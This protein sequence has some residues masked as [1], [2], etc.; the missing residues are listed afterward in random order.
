[1][2]SCRSISQEFN[3]KEE[4]LIVFKSYIGITSG[5]MDKKVAQ[6]LNNVFAT[7]IHQS[8]QN[9]D[10][11]VYNDFDVAFA[12]GIVFKLL[13]GQKIEFL[14]YFC[15]QYS[16]ANDKQKYALDL[17]KYTVYQLDKSDP[18]FYL[19]TLLKNKNIPNQQL[20]AGI[21]LSK[22][23]TF[24]HLCELGSFF[25]PFQTYFPNVFWQ[26]YEKINMKDV[27]PDI[28]LYFYQPSPSFPIL[29]LQQYDDVQLL[30]KIFQE[31]QV[32]M[33]HIS[34]Q[35]IL[36]AVARQLSP[37][38]EN[39]KSQPYKVPSF[40]ELGLILF[41]GQPQLEDKISKFEKISK[42]GETL[43]FLINPQASFEII[44]KDLS[45]HQE[46]EVVKDQVEQNQNANQVF[47]IF[48]T[49][50]P[51]SSQAVN[52]LRKTISY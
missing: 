31:Y 5:G 44:K 18:T 28:D 12:V 23:Y 45:L 1:M 32:F 51:T 34:T 20:Q 13:V 40:R 27:R 25:K 43:S 10:K 2:I 29:V 37:T 48:A 15:A 9:A 16:K 50:I 21:S 30:Y 4:H 26:S 7:N 24:V 19:N 22:I 46:Q 49:Q 36:D 42:I 6:S 14:D 35:L 33:T 41:A 38:S 52:N 8:S 39:L 17:L 47:D 3:L 11:L